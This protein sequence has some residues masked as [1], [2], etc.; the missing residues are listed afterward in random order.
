MAETLVAAVEATTAVPQEV[1]PVVAPTLTSPPASPENLTISMPA[2]AEVAGEEDEDGAASSEGGGDGTTAGDGTAAERTVNAKRAWTDE[3]DT[4]LLA[5]VA[6]LG[7]QRWSL[8]SSHL[9][10]RVGKQCRE[11]WFNHLCPEVK[12]GEWTP[13]EDE[14]ITIGVKELGTKWSEIVKRLPGR[15]DNAIKNRFNS[16]VRRQLRIQ[17]RVETTEEEP[18]APPKEKSKRKRSPDKSAGG[19]RDDGGEASG[20][21]GGGGGSGGGGGGG[22]NGGARSRARPPKKPKAVQPE[23]EEELVDMVPYE[24]DDELDEPDELE[25]EH[26]HSEARVARRRRRILQLA[27]QLACEADE[28]AP[29]KREAL[30][31]LL[32]RETRLLGPEA[33]AEAEAEGGGWAGAWREP[34]GASYCPLGTRRQKTEELPPLQ[35]AD[36]ELDPEMGGSFEE[37]LRTRSRGDGGEMEELLRPP[38]ASANGRP[39]CSPTGGVGKG[40]AAGLRL[41]LRLVG[42]DEHDL[43][44]GVLEAAGAMAGLP[45][46]DLPAEMLSLTP[47]HACGPG[48]AGGADDWF[49]AYH[50][51]A[52]ASEAG[53][54]TVAPGLS[55]LLSPSGAQLGAALVDAF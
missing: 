30:V 9:K 5:T 8:I 41:D 45:P 52:A 16:N 21:A 29:E 40:L 19:R 12:K 33:E 24:L 10:G 14:L 51:G 20:E 34:G 49:T 2:D 50:S 27:T 55:P 48:E 32:T 46:T 25:G 42:G 1:A 43:D 11:R 23:R 54:G 15:T 31:Q 7:P 13:E 4:E 17:R 18:S 53:H 28:G 35:S 47:A 6:R 38:L 37:L 22:G 3:E 39:E 44:V 36:L 26:V